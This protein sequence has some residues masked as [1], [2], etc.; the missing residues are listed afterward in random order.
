MMEFLH[1]VPL[2]TT[3]HSRRREET[4]VT[5]ATK[6]RTYLIILCIT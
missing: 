4:D 6:K 2:L 1:A 3:K 5:D